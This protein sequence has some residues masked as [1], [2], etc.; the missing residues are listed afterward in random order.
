VSRLGEAR[1]A[2][3]RIRARQG[4]LPDCPEHPKQRADRKPKANCEQCWRRYILTVDNL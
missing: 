1:A 3:D 4:T 2:I